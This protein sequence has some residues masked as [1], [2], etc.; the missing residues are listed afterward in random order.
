[1]LLYATKYI[2]SWQSAQM[3]FTTP[4]PFGAH[5]NI[6]QLQSIVLSML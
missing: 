3:V 1:M 5:N 4:M 2:D 6:T